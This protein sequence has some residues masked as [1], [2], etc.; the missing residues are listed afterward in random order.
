M[1]T[2]ITRCGARWYKNEEEQIMNEIENNISISN[3]ALNHSRNIGGIII[4][5]NK[6]AYEDY[7]QNN[8]LDNILVK[9][10]LKK[11]DFE[12]YI[13]KYGV[14]ESSAIEHER[15]KRSLYKIQLEN[16]ALEITKKN[17]DIEMYKLQLDEI[18][19]KIQIKHC[20]E[21]L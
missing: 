20:S 3:I 19:Y 7:C 18:N 8:N 21:S 13:K 14:K 16:L 10:N 5:I 6:I 12:M 15:K 2:T 11:D 9:Y 1:S 4:R 17:L